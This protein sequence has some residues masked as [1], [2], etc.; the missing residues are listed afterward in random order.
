MTENIQFIGRVT[1]QPHDDDPQPEGAGGLE[2][3]PAISPEISPA[4]ATYFRRLSASLAWL[5]SEREI[6]EK[7][8]LE[9]QVSESYNFQRSQFVRAPL[10]RR[11]LIALFPAKHFK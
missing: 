3:R 5:A 11:L 9:L 10:W 4:A 7:K 2:E 8:R 1:R 6:L